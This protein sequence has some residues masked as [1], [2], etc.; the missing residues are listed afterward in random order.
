MYLAPIKPDQLEAALAYC[1]EHWVR[2]LYVT[3]S[4]KDFLDGGWFT[5]SAGATAR[6]RKLLA[7]LVSRLLQ[8][9]GQ[10]KVS[11]T[12][13]LRDWQPPEPALIE[14]QQ[15]EGPAEW[16]KIGPVQKMEL[17]RRVLADKSLS[18]P[19]AQILSFFIDRSRADTDC[20]WPSL[21]EIA[22]GAELSKSTVC[23][24]LIELEKGRWFRSVPPPTNGGRNHRTNYFDVLASVIRKYGLGENRTVTKNKLSDRART[25]ARGKL[26]DDSRTRTR[27]LR[28]DHNYIDQKPLSASRRASD[29]SP[30]GSKEKDVGLVDLKAVEAKPRPTKGPTRPTSF[31]DQKPGD[32]DPDLTR[33]ESAAAREQRLAADDAFYAITE[34][35]DGR[36]FNGVGDEFDPETGRQLPIP[37]DDAPPYDEWQTG[38]EWTVY[39]TRN[40]TSWDRF[41]DWF[42]RFGIPEVVVDNDFNHDGLAADFGMDEEAVKA[43]FAKFMKTVADAPFPGVEKAIRRFHGWLRGEKAKWVT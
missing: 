38:E 4:E 10:T 20:C 11:F 39:R 17:I 28:D 3:D 16:G 19:Q 22:S 34:C 32:Y 30:S 9:S 40:L 23:L 33:I 15:E 31:V 43:S 36:W 26:S 2:G 5:K 13:Y 37:E 6:Q 35:S 8:T 29:P 27:L 1:R 41:D 7:A 21:A 24:H 14:P 25:V 12:R 18:R 42:F